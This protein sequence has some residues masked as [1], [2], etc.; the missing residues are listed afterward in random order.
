VEDYEREFAARVGCAHAFSFASGRMSLYAILEALGIGAGDEVVL[1]GYTCVVVPNAVLYRGATP[2]Y[3]DIDPVTFNVDVGALEAAIT[4]RT[5]ALYAQHTFGLVCDID[6]IRR[7]AE[8]HQ[9]PVIEDVGHALGAQW[10]GIPAG[11]L[12]DAALFTSDHSKVIGTMVGGMATTN[13]PE[14]ALRLAEAQVL[15]AELPPEVVSGIRRT[16]LLEH[17]LLAPPV[18]WMGR[19]AYALLSRAGV[20]FAFRD[21]PEVERPTA[22]PYPARFPRAL[23]AIGRSQLDRLPGNLRHRRRIGLALEKR[24]EWLGDRLQPDA[25]NHAFLRY[26]IQLEDR[27]SFARLFSRHFDLGIW[28]TSVVHGRSSAFEQVRYREGSCPNAE[29]AARRVFTFPTHERVA[30]DFLLRLVD[31]HLA[32]IRSAMVRP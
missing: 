12:G 21:E 13:R 29:A 25:S 16:F 23:A 24:L 10:N 19:V 27:D 5:R 7:V 1:P 17:A 31:A 32:Q 28:F 20:L 4:P 30:P 18:A 22:Y 15:A 14:I 2:V 3:V 9:L 6:G 26:A 11:A 8:R